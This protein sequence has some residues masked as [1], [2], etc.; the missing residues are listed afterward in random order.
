MTSM[1]GQNKNLFFFFLFSFNYFQYSAN[2]TRIL[3]I[4]RDE[5][6]VIKIIIFKNIPV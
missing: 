1:P 4:F 2:V 3:Y 5:R 6:D